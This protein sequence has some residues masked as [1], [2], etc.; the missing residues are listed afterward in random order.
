MNTKGSRVY[1]TGKG[2]GATELSS[3]S[4]TTNNTTIVG[5]NAGTENYGLNCIFFGTNAGASNRFGNVNT[6]IGSSCGADATVVGCLLMGN[7]CGSQ[8]AGTNNIMLGHECCANAQSAAETVVIGHYAATDMAY[9]AR[10]GDDRVPSGPVQP[11]RGG[12]LH[13]GVGVRSK[14][15]QRQLELHVRRFQWAEQHQRRPE[16]HGGRFQWAEQSAGVL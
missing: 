7:N 5:Q 16:L 14:Q 3:I 13:G 9:T 8:L 10:V 2:D 15:P 4:T 1:F 12:Q 11:G 6:F